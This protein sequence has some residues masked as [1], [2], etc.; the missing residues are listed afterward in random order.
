MNELPWPIAGHGYD[1]PTQRY[2]VED[3]ANGQEILLRF[4][5]RRLIAQHSRLLPHHPATTGRRLPAIAFLLQNNQLKSLRQSLRDYLLEH[6]LRGQRLPINCPT[7]GIVQI[8]IIRQQCI[9]R[10][11]VIIVQ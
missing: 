7:C 1:G 5:Q 11:H 9:I 2:L 3:P 10:D 6:L 8:H 4:L